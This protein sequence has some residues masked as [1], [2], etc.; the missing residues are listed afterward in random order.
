ME[1]IDDCLVPALIRRPL[2]GAR[3][4][5][6]QALWVS[7]APSTV[8]RPVEEDVFERIRAQ[9][10][11]YEA[12]MLAEY[13]NVPADEMREAVANQRASLDIMTPAQRDA[14]RG[15]PPLW[16]WNDKRA[17]WQRNAAWDEQIRV[18]G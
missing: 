15:R 18:A 7:H 17:Y 12:A 4:W 10:H 5:D 9:C 3:W 14:A 11:D 2:E 13:P 16:V 8:V 1:L 6:D